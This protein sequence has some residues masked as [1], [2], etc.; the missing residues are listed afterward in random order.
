MSETDG[1]K[2]VSINDLEFEK[3]VSITGAETPLKDLH[4]PKEKKEKPTKTPKEK[5]E[6]VVHGGSGPA[7]GAKK[8][9]VKKESGLGLAF[10]KEENFG[11]WYSD[12]VVRGEMIEY[13][14][15]SGCYILR[16]WSYAI[17]E[18][19]KGRIVNISS[20]VGVT[21]NIGQ[22][23]Y[24]AAKAGVIG[25]TKSVA[26]EYSSRG[27][28]VNAVAPGFISSDMTAKLNEETEKAILKTIPLG[29]YGLP[30]EVAGLVKFLALDPAAYITG[31]TFNI[32][33]GMVM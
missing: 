15:V 8:K 5:K 10:K 19:I 16:P 28:T 12:L 29:R 4:K 24:A 1:E 17:W 11:D 32:D 30:E 7:G 33:G 9:E 6:G 22:A 14:D 21:G 31:Q 20:V 23:N 27:I 3:N 18:F 26:R 25:L 13:Y 2:V